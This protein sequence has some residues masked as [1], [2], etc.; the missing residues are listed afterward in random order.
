MRVP[1]LIAVLVIALVAVC[2]GGEVPA[3]SKDIFGARLGE[4]AATIRTRCDELGVAYVE[5]TK[6]PLDEDFPGITD[7]I[8]GCLNGDDA[9]ENMQVSHYA[10]Q[11]YKISIFLKDASYVNQEVLEHS[12]RQKYG[13]PRDDFAAAFASRTVFTTSIDGKKVEIALDPRL[14]GELVIWYEYKALGDL[15]NAEMLR[16]KSSRMKGAPSKTSRQWYEGGTLHDKTMAQWH[17]GVASDRLATSGDWV[18]KMAQGDKFIPEVA[19]M[20]DIKAL[21]TELRACMDAAYDE[22][23]ADQPVADFAIM[24]MVV[25]GWLE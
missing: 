7:D 14:G 20:D 9:V 3:L 1:F 16:V 8:Q 12:L 17:S 11:V 18:S 13:A 15:A 5:N 10:G 23:T 19:S 4:M 24:C 21:A 25:M 2:Q 6:D 22:S